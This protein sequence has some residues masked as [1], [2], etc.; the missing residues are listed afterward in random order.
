MPALISQPNR[1]TS[2][3]ALILSLLALVA[4][5]S[6]GSTPCANAASGSCAVGDDEVF[7]ANVA[8]DSDTV[9]TA[10]LDHAYTG[11]HTVTFPDAAGTIPLLE[12]SQTWAGTN[13]FSTD[14][15]LADGGTGASTAAAARTNLDV[16]QAGTDNSTDVTL[17]GTPDYITLA[18]QVLTRSQIDLTADVTGDLPVTEGGTGASTASAARTALGV[19]IGSDVIAYD[20]SLNTIAP[21]T[22]TADNFIVGNSV[23]SGWEGKTP[24]QARTSLGLGSLATESVINDD[25]WSG[26][27]LTVSNGGT[28]VSTLTDHYVLV[29]SGSSAVTAVSPSTSGYVLTSNGTGSDPTFQ[30]ASTGITEADQWRLHTDFSGDA[31]PITSNLEQNDTTGFGQLGTGMSESSGIFTFPSTGIWLVSFNLRFDADASSDLSIYYGIETTTNNSTYT[32]ASIPYT[33][34]YATNAQM[35]GHAET[36]FDVTS[37]TTH[38]VRFGVGSLGTNDVKGN[39]NS[40]VTYMTFIRLGDT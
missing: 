9:Y 25:D 28:G 23:G 1:I 10:T 38:K 24:A 35:S 37:T 26:T 32:W 31:L 39:T 19:A 18:G 14:I 34:L 20:G 16:D 33:S 21:I 11:D 13:T 22:P 27:D 29:G 30:A 17:A 3:L 8:W 36:V 7:A 15:A 40:N 6:M 4:V 5:F 2:S 12:S